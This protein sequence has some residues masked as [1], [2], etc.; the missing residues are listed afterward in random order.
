[1]KPGEAAQQDLG[2][3]D[4][5]VLVTGA[6]R[7]IG[8]AYAEVLARHGACVALH[9][10]GVD[11]DG[12]DANPQCAEAAAKEFTNRGLRAVAFTTL[13]D[14]FESCRKLVKDVCD[15]LGRLDAL[16]HNAGVV[17]WCDPSLVDQDQYARS[18][19]VNNE[20]AF[21]LASA[22]LPVMRAQAIG[23]IVLTTSG[24]ALE[25]ANGSDQL[26]LYA[27]GKGAQL[28]LAMALARGAG[29]PNILTN[30]I[31][32][33][34]KTRI[35]RRQVPEG[36]YRPEAVAGAVAWLASPLCNVTG[37][38][39]RASDGELTLSRFVNLISRNLGPSADDP[40]VAGEAISGMVKASGMVT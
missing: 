2:L 24:W 33:V 21:W 8:R 28:G 16:I 29:H 27:H 38:L 30:L 18:A 4:R 6:A 36:R 13:L 39:L 14:Q 5:V 12:R 20:A 35:L 7:G 10:A 9:D 31:A 3:T 22:V 19:S 1:M 32:P 17:L 40:L 26:A 25:P 23:R 15:R 37:C 34:A 11:Q